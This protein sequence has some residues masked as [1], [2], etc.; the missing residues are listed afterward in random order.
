M[1]G[2]LFE[3][4]QHGV[5]AALRE[6]MDLIN[7]IY[8]KTAAGWHILNI[9]QQFAHVIDTGTRRSIDLDEVH[10]S[11]LPYL[12]AGRTLATGCGRYPDF[13]IEALGQDS[14]NSR[15]A[16]AASTCEQVCVM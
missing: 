13:T 1:F 15:F 3:S 11:A 7:Q 10:A 16:N 4:L 6:H 8:L 9:I 2:R 5:E 14:G 12:L